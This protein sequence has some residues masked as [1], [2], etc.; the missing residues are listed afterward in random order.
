MTA[1]SVLIKFIVRLLFLVS[2]I[3]TLH[4]LSSK[5][6]ALCD[7]IGIL[8]QFKYVGTAFAY[9]LP[10]IKQDFKGNSDKSQ[11]QFAHFHSGIKRSKKLPME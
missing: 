5:L 11:N 3:R 2:G 1:M 10:K 4:R 9:I 7:G 6:K 8:L